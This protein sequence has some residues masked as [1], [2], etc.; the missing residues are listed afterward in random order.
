MLRL[1]AAVIVLV[2]LP[3]VV[4]A[5]DATQPR[6]SSQLRELDEL[7]VPRL[8]ITAGKLQRMDIVGAD[9]D[10]IGEVEEVLVDRDGRVV[11]IVAE[12]EGFLGIGEHEVVVWLDQLAIQDDGDKLVTTMTQEQFENL[13]K[14]D[15]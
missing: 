1:F 13:P 3:A 7:P 5:Q 6:D 12:F 8:G 10:E 4:Q 9:G 11:A 14:W 2:S 15:D